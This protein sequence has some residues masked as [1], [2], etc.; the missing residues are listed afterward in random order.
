MAYLSV[1]VRRPRISLPS[2]VSATS[3]PM[4]A[5]KSSAQESVMG[6]G[7]KSPFS[8]RISRHAPRQSAAP[9]KPSSG[10]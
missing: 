1:T 2:S 8:S 6:S 5:A 3:S 4:A 7:Q 10:V 9:M